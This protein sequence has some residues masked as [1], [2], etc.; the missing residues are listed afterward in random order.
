MSNLQNT[1]HFYRAKQCAEYLGIGVSTFWKWVQD[2]RIPAGTRLS[3]RCTV[4]SIETLEQVVAQ[5]AEAG[6]L[7]DKEV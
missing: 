5:A 6:K 1:K 2:G 4:W 7:P 3:S